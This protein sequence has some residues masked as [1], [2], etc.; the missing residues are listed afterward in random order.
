M[1]AFIVSAGVLLLL[2]VAIVLRPLLKGGAG[3]GVARERANF[4]IYRDQFVEL[5]NDLR[6]GVLGDGQF[7]QAKADLDRRVL[8]E[9]A[10]PAEGV[11]GARRG[12]AAPI[13]VGV[14]IPVAAVLLYLRFGSLEGLDVTHHAAR[15]VS[16]V[17]AAH[18]REMTEKLAARM[19]EK[20]DDAEGW[21]MLG[22]AY[23]AL[24]RFDEAADALRKAVALNPGNADLL[25]DLAEA[26]ALRSGRTLA[27]EPTRLLERALKLEP[28]NDKALA[29]SGSAAFERKDYKAAIRHWETLLKRPSV[30]GELAQA[31][32]AGLSEARLLS[33]GKKTVAAVPAPGR[34]SGTVTL[35]A[36]LRPRAAP[37]DTVFVYARAAQGPRMPLAIVKVQ[38]KDLPYN[39]SLDDSM[40][41]IPEM[42]LSAFNEVIVGARVSR[43][44]SA[45]PAAGDLEGASATVS[46]G[47]NGV[48]VAIN[49]VVR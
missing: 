17:T 12:H 10:R 23:R 5:E 48:T 15:D 24:E 30:S 49:V 34:V 37:E 41:M 20:P 42:K 2:A 16:S 21:V 7:D 39:F 46:P 19:R 35:D 4:E 31:L 11:T 9:A 33:T 28:D 36:A 44:G 38:V 22:R 14:L 6:S 26:L 3:T 27:G 29:L 1:T 43:S 40:A 25:A 47:A 18:F 32:S 45:K 8:E 13:A